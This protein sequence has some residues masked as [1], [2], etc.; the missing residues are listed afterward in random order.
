MSDNLMDT[1]NI[2]PGDVPQEKVEATTPHKVQAVGPFEAIEAYIDGGAGGLYEKPGQYDVWIY[3][4]NNP[5]DQ[6]KIKV[7]LQDEGGDE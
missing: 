6:K 2:V 1:Y 5:G 3:P 7:N 4:E